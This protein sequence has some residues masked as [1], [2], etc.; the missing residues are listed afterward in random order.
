MIDYLL[1]SGIFV[2][3]LELNPSMG[4]IWIRDNHFTPRGIINVIIYPLKNIRMWYPDMWDIN[5]FI[6]ILGY[7]GFK[8]GLPYI[9][10]CLLE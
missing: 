4:N 9:V 10:K 6:W 5:F 7:Y 8:S 2:L 3:Y 1:I